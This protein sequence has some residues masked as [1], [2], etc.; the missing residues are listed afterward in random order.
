[1]KNYI[2][3][4][5]ARLTT[6]IIVSKVRGANMAK[7]LKSNI[8]ANKTMGAKVTAKSGVDKSVVD[9]Y[10]GMNESEL[11]S[12]MIKVAATSKANGTLN[13]AE[14]ENFYN[15]MSPMLTA[16]QRKKLKALINT[17]K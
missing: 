8:G 6:Y 9:K 1:M 16:E 4:S 13:D 17:L 14:L 3:V 11:M 12:E 2:F 5:K 15:Q 7:N 10:S